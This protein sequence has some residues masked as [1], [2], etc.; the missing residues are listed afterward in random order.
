MSSSNRPTDPLFNQQ[1]YLQNVGQTGGT[2]RI[3]LN[4]LPVW[5]NY[6]GGGVRVAIVDDGV[7]Y[8]HPDLNDN[9]DLTTDI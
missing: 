7:D 3:D 8:R 2:P 1:W 6:T 9:Y 5:Q 4:V